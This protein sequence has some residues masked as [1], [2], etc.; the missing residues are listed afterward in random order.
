[1]GRYTSLHDY[2]C[3]YECMHVPNMFEWNRLL[4]VCVCMYLSKYDFN[5][6]PV[7]GHDI[8]LA[9]QWQEDVWVWRE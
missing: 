3:R 6:R 1:M 4:T 2:V 7:S 8:E 5:D 9:Q